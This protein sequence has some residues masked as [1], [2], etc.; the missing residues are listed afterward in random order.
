[1]DID[2]RNASL[3]GADSPVDIGIN[4]ETIV[5]IAPAIQEK[6]KEEIDA[7]G[8]LVSPP[9][10]DPHLH[11]DAVLTV[12]DPRYNESGTL[13]EGIQIWGRE[14]RTSPGK[15][16]S[17]MPRRRCSGSSPTAC[18]SSA[19]MQTPRTRRFLQWKRFLK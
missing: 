18:S 19:P 12:G 6:G 2:I 14:N 7:A 11:L 9:L 17:K 13:L 15:A 10:C 5:K 8:K 1:M 3:P 4:G 16:W